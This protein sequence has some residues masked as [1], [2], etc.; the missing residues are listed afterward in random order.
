[1]TPN[2][3]KI[4]SEF[5]LLDNFYENAD[6]SADGHNWATAAIAPDYT[7]R[8]WP[9]EYAQ[10][11]QAV[12]TSKAPSPP[13]APPAGYLWTNALQAGIA[14]RNYG[15]WTEEKK[16]AD[17]DSDV[18]VHDPA[19]DRITN[20]DY[21]PLQSRLSRCRTRRRVRHKE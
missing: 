14:V 18:L 1:M 17:G 11:S 21:P 7:Q 9:S 4:A 5:V 6:V 20:K 8:I 2:L 16:L 10:P 12:W 13:T 19:L 15:E 3:H